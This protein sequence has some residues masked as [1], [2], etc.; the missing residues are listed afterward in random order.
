MSK[1]K[2][3]EYGH[4]IVTDN[5]ITREEVSP[6]LGRE[7][8]LDGLDPNKIYMVYRP[9]EE[10]KK[11]K[12]TVNLKPFVNEHF[13]VD[14]ET[15]NKDK[16]IGTIGGKAEIKGRELINDLSVWDI[17]AV[18]LVESKKKEG[19]SG[20]YS[21]DLDPTPGYFDGEYYDFIFRNLSFN[22]VALVKKGRVLNAK[23][24]D[25]AENLIINRGGVMPES[26]KKANDS[27]EKVEKTVN[28][29]QKEN[30]ED[31]I[32]KLKEQL[33][34]KDSKISDLENKLKEH[35]KED[36]E[37]FS[38]DSDESKKSNASD[39]DMIQKFVAKGIADNLKARGLAEQVLGKVNF[40][41]DASPEMIFDSV[42]EAKKQDYKGMSLDTKEALVKY[43]AFSASKE[44]QSKGI[45]VDS[46]PTFN[47][48]T[49]DWIDNF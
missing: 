27:K 19:L 11:A 16:W 25:T 40:A 34:I 24:A 8:P 29:N 43:M 10:I 15:P 21:Y 42:L 38:K 37:R 18:E 9:L 46:N 41:L 47:S 20:G 17:N 33:K 44:K 30:A 45:A 12:D 1:R 48:K 3:N 23:I 6:Y 4:M 2:V 7:L 28:D 49:A 39:E 26:L 36:A 31:D 13:T 5:V 32:S 14:Q 35:Q 22:H